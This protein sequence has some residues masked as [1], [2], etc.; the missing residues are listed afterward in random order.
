MDIGYVLG[1]IATGVALLG[2][3]IKGTNSLT[4]I[5]EKMTGYV[6]QTEELQAF[7]RTSEA[8]HVEHEHRIKNL[9][10]D[11]SELRDGGQ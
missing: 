8:K 9:E 11:V 5:E 4:R 3:V 10:S 1:L 6:K 2:Y 7:R